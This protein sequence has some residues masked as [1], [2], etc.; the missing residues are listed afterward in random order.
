MSACSAADFQI[1]QAVTG[2][3]LE[4]SRARF[5]NFTE[6]DIRQNLKLLDWNFLKRLED[7]PHVFRSSKHAGS[8][9]LHLME[10]LPGH[11]LTQS[12]S[13]ESPS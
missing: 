6:H 9:G 8:S 1:P 3:T 5:Q 2:N 10:Q 12:G 13:C 4:F 7:S 11:M